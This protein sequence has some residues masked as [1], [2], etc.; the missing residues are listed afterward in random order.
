LP[1][2]MRGEK[3][4]GGGFRV[5]NGFSP[6]FPPGGDRPR[7][8]S[9]SCPPVPALQPPPSSPPPPPREEAPLPA[10]ATSTGRPRYAPS[11][12]RAAPKGCA[13]KTP[14]RTA[15]A[16]DPP[17]LRPSSLRGVLRRNSTDNVWQK[18]RGRC[19]GETPAEGVAEGV[20]PVRGGG[21]DLCRASLT[22]LND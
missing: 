13:P 17:P 19:G 3:R 7:L 16:P 22:P 6:P 14:R 8:A 11:G 18:T 5:K 9:V 15:G 20:R 4:N 10:P 21:A 1:R 12:R 2:L